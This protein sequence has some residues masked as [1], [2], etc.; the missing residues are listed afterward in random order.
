M[1]SLSVPKTQVRVSLSS[2]GE[3]VEGFVFV[4]EFS[5]LTHGTERVGELLNQHSETFLPV[6]DSRG[7]R[8][9]LYNKQAIISLTVLEQERR[10]WEVEELEFSPAE[11]IEI[12]LTNGE[13]MRGITYLDPRPEKS[14]VS[15]LL[16]RQEESFVV[17][18]REEGVTY[19]SKRYILRVA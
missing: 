14:R 2:A 9:V 3:T 8:V 6:R 4:A 19:V 12:T 18:V 7:E 17:L 13:V 10:D 16:N 5:E 11:K 15:D 1:S